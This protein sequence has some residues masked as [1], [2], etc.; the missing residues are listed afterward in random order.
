MRRGP[1]TVQVVFWLLLITH[2]CFG[3]MSALSLPPQM[4]LRGR[5]STPLS[6][7]IAITVAPEQQTHASVGGYFVHLIFSRGFFVSTVE[8]C[9]SPNPM[10]TAAV[11]YRVRRC[12]SHQPPLGRFSVLDIS[13]VGR[14][15]A[16]K[17][18]PLETSLREL[19]EDVS[20]GIGTLLVGRAIELGKPP[21]GDVV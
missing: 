7:R 14:L 3:I 15:A 17:R 1:T 20:F 11:P 19:S 9:A 4:L 10:K 5:A 21:Q 12:L 16:P 2:T 8:L 6:R 18:S 13:I